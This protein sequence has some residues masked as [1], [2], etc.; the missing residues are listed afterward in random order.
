MKIWSEF[1]C[2]MDF[3]GDG[4]LNG[5]ELGDLNCVWREGDIL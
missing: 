5:E 1:F 3:D 4:K 2:R